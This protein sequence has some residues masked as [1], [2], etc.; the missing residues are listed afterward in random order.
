VARRD[1]DRVAGAQYV[2]PPV[3][4]LDGHLPSHHHTDVDGLAA[5]AADLGSGVP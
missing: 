3:G 4:L 2:G 1:R 5:L